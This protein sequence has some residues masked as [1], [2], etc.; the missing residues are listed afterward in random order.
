VQRTEQTKILLLCFKKPN[1][2]NLLKVFIVCES[3]NAKH[4]IAITSSDVLHTC[5]VSGRVSTFNFPDV[6]LQGLVNKVVEKNLN[7]LSTKQ[8]KL[9]QNQ[10]LLNNFVTLCFC[11]LIK[12]FLSGDMIVS[13]LGQPLFL[14][15]IYDD[16]TNTFTNQGVLNM[17]K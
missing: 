7:K 8:W 3:G 14:G 17:C 1:Q 9:N 13:A 15:D 2:V 16:S 11:K 4:T 10:V 12:N 6:K 5:V